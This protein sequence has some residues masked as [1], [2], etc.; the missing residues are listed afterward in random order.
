M[1]CYLTCIDRLSPEG[2]DYYVNK[3]SSE[4]WSCL[5]YWLRFRYFHESPKVKMCYHFVSIP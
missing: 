3:K 2:I 1:T 5:K 4:K